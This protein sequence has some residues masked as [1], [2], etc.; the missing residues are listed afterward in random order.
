MFRK[1]VPIMADETQT[2][3][4]PILPDACLKSDFPATL[5]KYA[6]LRQVLWGIGA[7][8]LA[9]LIADLGQLLFASLP[10]L[11]FIAFYLAFALTYFLLPTLGIILLV[12]RRSRFFG[13]GLLAGAMAAWVSIFLGGPLM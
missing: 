6:S 2:G 11:G 4:E 12:P 10:A 9:W 5:A 7:Y 1:D 3:V 13:L 8:V